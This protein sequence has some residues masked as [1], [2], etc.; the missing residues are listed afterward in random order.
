MDPCGDTQSLMIM[1]VENLRK[2]FKIAKM[3]FTDKIRIK[4][5]SFVHTF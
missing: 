3:K 4:E 1:G 2:N 5:D